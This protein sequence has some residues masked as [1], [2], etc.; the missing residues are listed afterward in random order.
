MDFKENTFAYD[1]I[2]PGRIAFGWGRRAE[3][4][5]LG[6]TLGRRAVVF[7]G[8]PDEQA[9]VVLP[10]IADSLHAS[11]IDMLEAG[12]ID[13]EPEAADVDEAAAGLHELGAGAGDFILAVGGGATIDLAKAVAAMGVH[14]ANGKVADYLEGVGRGYT[15]HRDPLPVMALPT[16]AGTGAEATYNAVIS[17]YDPPWKKSLR[18]PRLM[19]RVA[20][21]DPELCVTVPPAI[22][23]ASGM[24]AVTQLIESYISRKAQPIPQALCLQG[25]RLAIPAIVEAVENGTSRRAREAVSHAALLSGMALANSGL[26]MAHGVAPALGTHCR[27]PHGIACA[28]MLPAALRINR[29]AR[30]DELAHMAHVLFGTPSRQSPDA[31]VERLIDEIDRLLARVGISARLSESGV[32]PEHIPAIAKDSFGNSMRGNPVEL[33]EQ[34]LAEVLQGLL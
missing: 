2:A 23:A 29:D 28:I 26:G 15:L 22:T 16:T 7:C 20:L 19:P 12:A 31:A 34:Q 1:F 5:T 3:A 6:A 4:G 30:R 11:Q 33:N 13:H 14:A 24:D 8:L 9:A 10:E 32:K 21:V 25:L 17:N 18:D 27:L